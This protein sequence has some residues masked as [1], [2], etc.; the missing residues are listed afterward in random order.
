MEETKKETEIR[1]LDLWEVFL[2]CWWIV[3]LVGVIV[4]I[5]LFIFLSANNEPEYTATT[6]VYVMKDSENSTT[7]E[8]S[9]ANTLVNDYMELCKMDRVMDM[10]RHDLGIGFVPEEFIRSEKDQQSI[11]VL[12]LAEEIPQRYICL[13]KRTDASLS[14]AS[15]ELEQMGAYLIGMEDL[16]EFSDFPGQTAFF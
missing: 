7:G 9:I 12:R 14:P 6:I 3:A 15:K 11:H 10:V 13:V 1:L 8:V 4:F 2:Q 5:G 16:E